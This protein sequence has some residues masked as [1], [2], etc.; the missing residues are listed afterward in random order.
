MIW[1]AILGLLWL[2]CFGFYALSEKQIVKIRKSRYAFLTNFPTHAKFAAGSFLLLSM[3]LLRTQFSSSISFVALW[4]LLSPVLFIFILK[5]NN[6][7][8]RL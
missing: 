7:I 3:F 2:S 5:I 8:G 1:I 6:L 4:V